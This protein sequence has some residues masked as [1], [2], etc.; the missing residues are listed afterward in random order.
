MNQEIK[1]DEIKITERCSAC[2]HK[3]DLIV[4]LL[5]NELG[6]QRTRNIANR[7]TNPDCFRYMPELPKNWVLLHSKK[8]Q[9]NEQVHNLILSRRE[10]GR[11]RK[12][13]T[14]TQNDRETALETTS[15]EVCTVET[16]RHERTSK[17]HREHSY[18][19]NVDP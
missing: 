13:T 12:S 10:R 2:H 18:L 8:F 17:K 9:H 1:T 4:R 15:E 7:C 16:A 19:P 5:T 11:G 3:G 6:T 14:K